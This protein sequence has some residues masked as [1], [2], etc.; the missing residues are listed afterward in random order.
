MR[1]VQSSHHRS[2]T[3]SMAGHPHTG[4]PDSLIIDTFLIIRHVRKVHS[5]PHDHN[6]QMA[7]RMDPSAQPTST[8]GETRRVT[9]AASNLSHSSHGKSGRTLR[10]VPF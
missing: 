6:D 7:G 5:S 8:I 1:G 10:R 2:T 3:V 4:P 9:R